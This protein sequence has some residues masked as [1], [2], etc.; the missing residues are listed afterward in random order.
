MCFAY[1][2]LSYSTLERAGL[3]LWF[4][5]FLSFL[6]PPNQLSLPMLKSWLSSYSYPSTTAGPLVATTITIEAIQ[7]LLHANGYPIEGIWLIYFF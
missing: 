6:Q 4:Q 2:I 5:Y 7:D 1:E 3:M